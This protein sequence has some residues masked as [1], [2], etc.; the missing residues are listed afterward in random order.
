MPDLNGIYSDAA[1]QSDLYRNPVIVIPGILGSQL[2]DVKHD[3]AIWGVYDSKF[4]GPDN[5]AAMR[6][7]A[8]PMAQGVS[9][10]QLK[11][12]V[13]STKTL[14]RLRLKV[15][16][17]PVQPR[18]YAS[19]LTTLGVGGYKDQDLGSNGAIDYGDDHFSCFQFNY[20]WRRSN[21]ENAAKLDAFI[22]EKKAFVRKNIKEKFGVDRKDI[23]FDII[24]HSMGGLVARYYMRYGNQQIPSGK[25]ALPK[26]NWA[27]ARNVEKLIMVGTPNSGSV[28]AFEQSLK[29]QSFGPTWAKYLPYTNIPE[30]PASVIGTYPSIY[31]LMPRH[32]HRA[33]V[34][35][36]GKGINVFDVNLWDTYNLGLLSKDGE[37]DLAWQLPHENSPEKRRAIAKDHLRKCLLNAEKFHQALDKKASPPAHVSISLISGDAIRTKERVMLFPEEGR[38]EDNNYQ[39]GD[40]TVIRSSV[41][42]DDR[43]GSPFE[44]G[45]K[46]PIDYDRAL[47]LPRD[48]LGLTSDV[49]FT[50]NVLHILLE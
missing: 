8:I 12:D 46:S 13:V 5:P 15:I 44:P 28:L 30:Y 47:F 22:R 16:G 14:D 10:G 35:Q 17:I 11:D 1:K 24:A 25:N 42:A 41:L 6:Q 45:I 3:Q 27:G 20:D 18:A 32:R 37:Q 31:E 50:D 23:K 21:A 39:P 38:V 40:G 34:D 33:V 4:Q 49:T 48:H 7:V 36:E 43:A 26:L 2:H 19:I 29:G 9:L